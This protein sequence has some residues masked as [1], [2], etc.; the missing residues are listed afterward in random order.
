MVFSKGKSDINRINVKNLKKLSIESHWLWANIT[1]GVI[2]LPEPGLAI[3]SI[4]HYA[5]AKYT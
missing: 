1:F 5:K 3:N 2:F 4:F